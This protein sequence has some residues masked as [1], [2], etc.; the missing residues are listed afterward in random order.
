MEWQPRLHL[1]QI[2]A[3]SAHWE[4][5]VAEFSN[6]LSLLPEEEVPLRGPSPSRRSLILHGRGSSQAALGRWQEAATD[7]G[8][9]KRRWPDR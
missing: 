4:E 9:C 6:A 8:H 3:E 1:G 7:L 5:A 2:A